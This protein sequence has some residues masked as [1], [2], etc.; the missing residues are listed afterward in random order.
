MA[1][2]TI[3]NSF[4]NGPTNPADATKIN[5]NFNDVAA[6]VNNRYNISDDDEDSITFTDTGHDHSGDEKGST[7]AASAFPLAI[8]NGA[9]GGVL[10]KSGTSGA[11]AGGGTEAIAFAGTAFAQTPIIQ[12]LISGGSS[13]GAGS[14]MSVTT[15]TLSHAI[16]D[17]WGALVDPPRAD[18]THG[19]TTS[20]QGFYITN[21]SAAGFTINNPTSGAVTYTWIAI[22]I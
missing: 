16:W 9:R 10:V 12:V 4:T 8:N 15:P 19:I 1:D 17:E 22:G 14:W 7:L 6:A 5:E 3:P 20:M 11:I 21:A 18:H 2:L 13:Y